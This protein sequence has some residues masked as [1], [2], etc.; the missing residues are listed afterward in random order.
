MRITNLTQLI[1]AQSTLGDAGITF[2]ESHTDEHFL[3]YKDLYE[4]AL[5]C[6]LVLQKRGVCRNDEVILQIDDNKSLLIAFWACILGGMIP[7]PLATGGT[8]MHRQKLFNVWKILNRPHLISSAAHFEKMTGYALSNSL[9]SSSDE[10]SKRYINES[11]VL[12]AGAAAE[13]V[14]VSPQDIAFIQFS[15]GSTGNPKGIVLTHENLITNIQGISNAAQYS[16]SDSTLSWMPLTHDMGMIGFH[17]NPLLH[18]MNQCLIPTSLFVRRPALWLDALSR[19]RATITCSPNFGYRYFL[20][21]YTPDDHHDWNLSS[22]RIIYNGA[23]PISTKICKEFTDSMK[24]FGLRE[25]AM[26]PVYG[27]AEASVAVT[28]SDLDSDVVAVMVNRN[29]VNINDKVVFSEETAD[30]VSFADVGKPVDGCSLRVA[31]DDDHPVDAAVIGHIQIKGNNVTKG[32]YNDKQAS[33]QVFSADGWLK[34]GDLG[35]LSDKGSLFVTGR[36]KDIIFINGQNFYPHDIERIAEEIDTIELNKIAVG[37]FFNRNTQ[38][39]EVIAFVL[40]RGELSSFIQTA[41]QLKK[42]INTRCGFEIDQVIPVKNIPRTTSGKLQR[43]KLIAQYLDGKYRETT[44]ALFRLTEDAA[45]DF[46][47]FH[48]ETPI[49]QKLFDIWQRV[50]KYP[51]FDGKGHFFENGGDSLRASEV[52]MLVKKE[53]GVEMGLEVL[54]RYPAIPA[55]AAEIA[56]LEKAAPY[57]SIPRTAPSDTYVLSAA[58]KRMYYTWEVDQTSTAY[59][60]PVTLKI[61]GPVNREKLKAAI[62]TLISRHEVLRMSFKDPQQPVYRIH[63]TVALPF[64]YITSTP[65]NLD[66][67]FRELI[68]PFDLHQSPLFKIRLV[69]I[70]G[71]QH[72]LFLD[73]HHIICDGISVNIFIQE[74]FECY[75]GDELPSIPVTYSDYSDWEHRMFAS[76]SLQRQEL[77]W[78]QQLAQS[79]PVLDLPIDFNRPVIFNPKGEKLEVLLDKDITAGLSRIATQYACSLNT[80]LFTLYSVLLSKYSRQPQVAIGIAAA[81]RTHP[82]LLNIVGMFV[83]SLPLICDI[84]ANTFFPDLLEKH[85]HLLTAVLDNQDYP[86]ERMIQQAGAPADASRNRLFDTM[87]VYQNIGYDHMKTGDLQVQRHFFDPGIAKFDLSMEVFYYD[88]TLK[89]VIEYNTSLFKKETAERISGHFANLVKQITQKPDVSIHEI[90]LL[91]GVEYQDIIHHFNDTAADFP[92]HTTI[93]EQFRRQAEATPEAIAIEYGDDTINYR[94]LNEQADRL[95][96]ILRSKGI[97]TESIVAVLMDRRPELMVAILAVLKTG[98]CFLPIDISTPVRRISYMLTDSRASMMITGKEESDLPEVALLLSELPLLEILDIS[99]LTLPENVPATYSPA[100]PNSLAYIIYTSGT[101]GNPKGVMIEHHSLVNYIIW[102]SDMYVKKEEAAFPLYTSISF[103]LTITSLFLPLVTGNRIVI[104]SAAEDEFLM[105]RV[106][107]DNKVAVVKATPSHLIVIASCISREVARNSKIKRFIVG[108]E[109]LTRSIAAEIHLLFGGHIEIYNEYGPTEATVGCMIHQFDP[110][111]KAAAVPIGIPAA[112]TRIYVLDDSLKP[113]PIG[114][115]GELYISGEG[116]ARGY[117][118]SQELTGEKIINDPF[119]TGLRMYRTGDIA[120]RLPSGLIEYIGRT[121]K[122]VKISGHRIDLT[123]IEHQVATYEGIASSVVII[124]D[125]KKSPVIVAYYIVSGRQETIAEPLLRSYLSDRLPYYAMPAYFIQLDAYPLTSNGKVDHAALPAVEFSETSDVREID[126]HDKTFI[127]IWNEVFGVDNISASDNFFELGGDSIKAIQILSRLA[128]EGFMLTIKDILIYQTIRQ[129]VSNLQNTESRQE[130]EQGYIEGSRE[131]MPI[132]AWFFDQDFQRPDFYNHSMLLSFHEEIDLHLLQLSFQALIRQ[133]DGVRINYDPRRETLFY[134]KHHR[135]NPFTITSYDLDVQ[136]QEMKGICMSLK[137]SFDI[138]RDL[139]LKAA[140]FRMG[141]NHRML[142]ITAHH[143]IV[144]GVSWRI[145]LKDLYTAYKSLKNNSPVKFPAKTATAREWYDALLR[146]PHVEGNAAELAFWQSVANV[147]FSLPLDKRPADWR[148]MNAASEKRTIDKAGTRALLKLAHQV[149][150]S[151]IT[152]LLNAALAL[153]VRDWTGKN[154]CVIEQ[155]NHGRY[156]DG[157]NISRTVGWFTSMYPQQ[158][159]LHEGSLEAVI[160]EVRE[161]MTHVPGNGLGYGIFRY[162]HQTLQV[163]REKLSEIRFN[164]LGQFDQEFDNDLFAYSDDARGSNIDPDNV[165]TAKLEL[166]VIVLKNTLEIDIQ[167]NR[168]AHEKATI[169]SFADNLVKWLLHMM[170][171][172]KFREELPVTSFSLGARADGLDDD[173]L[174]VLFN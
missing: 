112:N 2:I 66:Q 67:L 92:L 162:L 58:Q 81:G 48:P 70:P 91:S 31:D 7:V 98:A 111:D 34:T 124:R 137:S 164:Y 107:L 154:V 158:L 143:L 119:V 131:L 89:Y 45:N 128:D 38:R 159:Q 138:S 46:D 30:A 33:G 103:D 57:H 156:L 118:G 39:D 100:E 65:E 22:L 10:I 47:V 52:C 20:K 63:E 170:A 117:L 163:N 1:Q 114:V 37:G 12:S 157:L 21:H 84:P 174:S 8:D 152:I 35:F 129:I 9:F 71:Q 42:L 125:G 171:Y 41:T 122:Q 96:F 166:N 108:G 49:E 27:L 105:R 140:V 109:E 160:R 3:L 145:L 135:D 74:L 80:L 121:D 36:A 148:T 123:E 53:L 139:L 150:K 161:Q 51:H 141:G 15:S 126:A 62:E 11:E 54:F 110:A 19:H 73:F 95:S 165:M 78:K 68:T 173:E 134:N 86:F 151:D 59:N 6:L 32:Y 85:H 43:F 155:E 64:D 169:Q 79:V 146:Y 104:Y 83:N 88:Q 40:H 87:F 28:I 115:K 168:L 106:V 149:Y 44:N 167:Y 13:P 130:Y 50:L 94:Q 29:H 116:V 132:E 61:D 172:N 24:R 75:R 69:N 147:P 17:L 26:C 90:N 5:Q 113:V 133:H 72:Y 4:K 120:K 99:S 55:L 76:G 56:N 93:H 136:G 144:D 101:T 60:I 14:T 102:A 23:E 16:V 25:Q 142:F 97:N 77:F 127:A 18:G 82:D 153:S